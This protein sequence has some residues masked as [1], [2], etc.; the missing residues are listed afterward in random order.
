MSR[1]FSTRPRPTA[2]S[3]LDLTLAAAGV[4]ALGWSSACA[5]R[6]WRESS[7]RRARVEEARRDLESARERVVP[8]AA[9]PDAA[10]GRQALLSL[11]AP[12]P[13]V[14]AALAS[15]MPGDVRLDGLS[16]E[17]GAAL[18]L[19]LRVVARDAA[20]YDLFLSR[21]EASPLF[22]GVTPGEE[23][24]DG[25]VRALVRARYEGVR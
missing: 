20:A 24:R 23:N 11:E 17:Y 2:R 15:V 8:A 3:P 10:F 14:L 7:E 12:P 19:Q 18:E 5:H 13:A 21:V 6:A 1:D 25:E 4:L 22:G 9:A 16:L